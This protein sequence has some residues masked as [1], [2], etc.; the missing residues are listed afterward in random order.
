MESQNMEI[1]EVRNE[2]LETCG[3]TSCAVMLAEKGRNI[4]EYA[5]T[6][7]TK[8]IISAADM[9][10]ISSIISLRYG[11]VDFDKKFGGLQMTI[12]VFKD[13]MVIATV[14]GKKFLII[15]VPNNVSMNIIQVIQNIKNNLIVEFQ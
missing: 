12:N 13:L 8:T 4:E 11:I 6:D 3:V 15:I 9:V 5:I 7:P 2:I 14:I 10:E 1:K